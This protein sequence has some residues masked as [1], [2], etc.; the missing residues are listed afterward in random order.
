MTSEQLKDDMLDTPCYPN[1]RC[2]MG[3]EPMKQG[4]TGDA[5]WTEKA[6]RNLTRLRKIVYGGTQ[7]ES[8][9][10]YMGVR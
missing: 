7:N 6:S 2:L 4:K 3:T 9:K 8:A 5:A 10:F 1:R